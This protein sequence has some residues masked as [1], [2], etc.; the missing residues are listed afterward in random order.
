M[1]KREFL[2]TLGSAAAF[3]YLNP[4][5]AIG[6]GYKASSDKNVL[7]LGGRNYLGPSIVNKFL[8][9][10]YNVTLLN[11][12]ITNPHFFN[13]L[14]VIICDRELENKEGI[15]AVSSEIKNQHWDIVVDTWQKSPKAVS[16]FV[17]EFK[18]NIGHYHYISTM[19]VYDKWDDKHIIESAPL[20]PLPASPKNISDEYRYAIRK[21]FSEVAITENLD[22]YTIYRSHG[23]KSYRATRPTDP[24]AEAY[25]PIRFMR[26]GEILV[27]DVESHHLQVTDV[28]SLCNF[29]I[30]CSENRTYGAFNVAYD[31]TPFKDYVS[32]LIL[33]TQMPKKLH[34]ITGEFLI[35]NGLPPYEV[36][37]LWKPSPKGSYYFNVQKARN[38]GLVNRP[39]AE[40]IT[41]QLNGYKS[42]YPSDP[43]KFGEEMNGQMIKYISKAKEEEVI[44]KWIEFKN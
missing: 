5:K 29:I 8:E 31:P 2:K 36:V 32:S 13:E 34:W 38:A 35:E 20:N 39:M 10:G 3:M 41:D 37:P 11:R 44:R 1:N 14:P 33:A 16:D 9:H 7:M 27:P 23:M 21:T 4:L 22:T 28:Q 17:E 18:D 26:G 40:M 12:G 25:W 30:N 19:S 43:I 24:N 15:K 42:R 6:T